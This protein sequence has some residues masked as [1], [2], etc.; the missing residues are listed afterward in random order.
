MVLTKWFFIVIVVEDIH[1]FVL[2]EWDFV[3]PILSFARIIQ[4][5]FE[6]IY[7]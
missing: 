4:K 5:F 3:A 1:G 2:K 6:L 7:C